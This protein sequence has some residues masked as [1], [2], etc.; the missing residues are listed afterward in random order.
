[1]INL[2]NCKLKIAKTR[3]KVNYSL[4]LS[5]KMQM[6]FQ[7]GEKV[8]KTIMDVKTGLKKAPDSFI[9]NPGWIHY[10]NYPDDGNFFFT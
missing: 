1:M 2:R 4:L 9:M 6:G 3:L 8:G 10:P 7:K 5:I